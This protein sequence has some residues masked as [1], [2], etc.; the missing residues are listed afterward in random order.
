[1]KTPMIESLDEIITIEEGSTLR[2]GDDIPHVDELF[3]KDFLTEEVN[4]PGKC[5]ECN[6][7]TEVERVDNQFLVKCDL[8]H[9]KEIPIDERTRYKPNFQHILESIS[10]LLDRNLQNYSSVNLPRFAK[11]HTDDGSNVFLVV[12]PGDLKKTVNEICLD[13]LSDQTPALLIIPSDDFSTVFE[14]QSL[15]SSGNLIY[16]VPFEELTETEMIKEQLQTMEDIRKFEDDILRDRLGDDVNP[17][18]NRIDSNPRHI[19]AE[20]N[21]MGMMRKHGIL[22]PGEGTRLEKV[23]ES[24]FSHIFPTLAGR[25]GEDDVA[26]NLPDNLF[27]IPE[28][29]DDQNEYE[30]IVGIVDTKSGED[31]NFSQESVTGKHDEYIRLARKQ[32][33]PSDSIAHIFLVLDIDGLQEIKFYDKMK[34]HYNQNEYLI[35]LMVDAFLSIM[36][37]YLSTTVSGE[38]RLSKGDFRKS[39]YPLFHR[40]SFN[41]INLASETREVGRS[42]EEYDEEYLS[43]PDLMVITKDIVLQHLRNESEGVGD[44]ERILEGYYMPA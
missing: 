17:V 42:Q 10:E 15:F 7:N 13:T 25:G 18:V 38:I 2:S 43:R 31:A 16:T 36:S 26:E 37:A 35:V 14:V 5:P 33:I 20:L 8:G 1:M 32:S 34:E 22:K 4:P 39:I 24:A 30:R 44:V 27:Y 3:E 21:H 12:S 29:T 40:D 6:A 28:L 41:E 19:L 9:I 23:G 11:A